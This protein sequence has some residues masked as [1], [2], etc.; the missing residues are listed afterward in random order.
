MKTRVKMKD[1][2]L[3]QETI[4]MTEYSEYNENGKRVSDSV[5][6]VVV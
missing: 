5:T 3:K 2:E 6:G 4:T 1:K